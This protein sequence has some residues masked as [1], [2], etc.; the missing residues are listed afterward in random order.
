M[1]DRLA[2]ILF[3]IS[4]VFLAFVA[5]FAVCQFRWFPHAVLSSALGE[6][7][8]AAPLRK[9]HHFKYPARHWL[10]GVETH[11]VNGEPAT[12]PDD[13]GVTL[14][15]SYWPD[16]DSRPG[17]RLIDHEGAV[18]HT[19]IVDARR[20]WPESPH[21]DP[22]AGQMHEVY[23]Y[24]HGTHLFH[25]GDVL[26]NV[27]YLGLVRMNARGEVLW[28]LDRR[29]HHSI[30]QTEDG[31]FWVCAMDWVDAEA[32]AERFPSLEG[33]LWD[34][35]ALLVSPD[36]KVLR[37][38][39]VLA[40]VYDSPYRALLWTTQHAATP[41]PRQDIMHMNDVEELPAAIAAEY[42]LFAAGDLLVSMR[43]VNLVMVFSPDTGKVKWC[44]AGMFTEQHDPDFIGGGW[45][46]VYDNRTDLTVDGSRFGGTRLVAVQPHTG[47]VRD[48][49]P[50]AD[51]TSKHERRF[52]SHQG[53]KAQ[54]LADDR[55]LITEPTAGRVFEIDGG[56]RT[57][58][59]WG[60]SDED[61]MV[62][63][64]LEGTRYPLTPR[65]VQEWL[66]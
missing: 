27:E 63:E 59:E 7:A 17:I 41:P 52:H 58:W 4:G 54:R 21:G 64:V 26:F 44:G 9:P 65:A 45:I 1:K 37:E 23:D 51:T 34:D 46:S 8:G 3:V 32:A 42:P 36:G 40:A 29:T 49:Y 12:P 66:R 30:E 5:G 6:L 61:G 28:T 53:G 47:A 48:I 2:K 18:L 16:R 31:N 11:P 55:W 15:T 13:L 60:Q 35:R 50:R 19:W 39:S 10:K 24:V 20:I 25:D 62:S 56:G 43:F 14:L 57:V 33:P 22:V 38:A